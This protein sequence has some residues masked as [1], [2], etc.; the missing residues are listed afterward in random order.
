MNAARAKLA[1]FG[2]E[3]VMDIVAL[4]ELRGVGVVSD[5]FDSESGVNPPRPFFVLEPSITPPEDQEVLITG[6]MTILMGY[7]RQPQLDTS[8]YK[9]LLMNA[10]S[11][12]ESWAQSIAEKIDTKDVLRPVTAESGIV[13]KALSAIENRLDAFRDSWNALLKSGGLDD[14]F[15]FWNQSQ[16]YDRDMLYEIYS[17]GTEVINM[18]RRGRLMVA[19]SKAMAGGSF[20]SGDPDAVAF[21]DIQLNDQVTG[22]PDFSD[23]VSIGD[24]V[25]A[26][27][28]NSVPKAALGDMAGIVSQANKHHVKQ[29]RKLA[30]RSNVDVDAPNFSGP[31]P[32]GQGD[33]ASTLIAALTGNTAKLLKSGGAAT[34][35]LGLFGAGD[36][37]IGDGLAAAISEHG[38]DDFMGDPDEEEDDFNEEAGDPDDDGDDTEQGG[39]F[40]RRDGFIDRVGKKHRA[41]KRGRQYVRSTKTRRAISDIDARYRDR[42]DSYD[43]EPSMSPDDMPEATESMRSG[44]FDPL[45]DTPDSGDGQ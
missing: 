10:F 24:A 15:L 2:R 6:L 31:A 12:P 36:I 23:K 20:M 17:F 41:R 14:S 5:I 19:Q 30:S 28:L 9:S 22:D 29:I 13:D 18:Q 26:L 1:M 44:S 43:T 33:I 40:R 35:K 38:G 25:R 42:A 3:S 32:I 21:G 4:I 8:S 34:T 11:L 45:A 39:L 37:S 7:I 27:S 16:A